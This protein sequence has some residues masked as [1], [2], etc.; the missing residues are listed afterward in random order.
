MGVE[1]FISH[2]GTPAMIW[3]DNGTSFIGA[4]KELRECIK[5]WNTINIA[6]ELPHKWKFNPP[7]ASYQGGIWERLVRSFK[8]VLLTILGMRR[9]TDEVLNTTFCLVEYALNSRPLNF[10]SADP[11]NLGPIT[12]NHFLLCIQATGVPSIVGV[13]EFD[14][15]KRYAPAQPYANAI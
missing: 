12:P 4:E 2:N 6:A 3:S 13:D 8:R 11:S 10:V 14:H 1:W 9:L 7:S 5:K 15:R